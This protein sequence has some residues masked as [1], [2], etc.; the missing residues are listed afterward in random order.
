MTSPFPTDAF[1]GTAADDLRWRPPYP[2]ALWSD[3]VRR[4]P[5]PPGGR[6]LDLASGPG[7]IALALADRFTEIWAVDQELEMIA[8]GRSE[9]ARRGLHHIRWIPSPAEALDARGQK[10]AII[11]I[12]EAFHRLDQPLIAARA[13]EW[14]APG[15]ALAI[16]GHRGP[17]G[18]PEP[19]HQ[20]IAETAALWRERAGVAPL[21]AGPPGGPGDVEAVLNA[22]GFES[23][24]SFDFLAARRWTVAEIAGYLRSMSYVSRRLLGEFAGAFESDLRARLLALNPAGVFE[25]TERFG[26]TFGRRPVVRTLVRRGVP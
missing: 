6:L 24:A 17:G 1:A 12:G 22:T 19:W 7:R 4:A 10:F 9:A 26:Y 25:E 20:L 18:G 8:A 16:L 3:F 23:V 11:A 15:G 14:L 5:P 2:A 13:H 21:P